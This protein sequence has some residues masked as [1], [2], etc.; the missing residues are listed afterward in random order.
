MHHGFSLEHQQ[1][2][3][4]LQQIQL[5]QA[6]LTPDLSGAIYF[7]FSIPRMGKR[8][9]VVL[10]IDGIV[11]VLEFKVGASA[12]D[13]GSIE[14]VVDYALDLKNFHRGSHN[15]RI[16]PILIPTEIDNQNAKTVVW[17][18]DQ[19]AQPL[20]I[21]SSLLGETIRHTLKQYPTSSMDAA[22]WAASGYQ[23]TPTIVEAA[24][25]LYKQ[26]D[27]REITRSEAGAGNLTQTAKRIEEIIDTA[28]RSRSEVDQF[29]ET[30]SWE[31]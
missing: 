28:K 1:K 31:R 14:Q 19:V 23:P 7:E 17:G 6:A 27:V 5:L 30:G 16:L 10:L 2:H 29:C 24:L 21:P 26:H 25:A 15:L 13:R 22:I 18:Q 9:D 8:A 20:C 11:F 4:W 12:S 3:A